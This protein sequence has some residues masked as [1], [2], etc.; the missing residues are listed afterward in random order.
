MNMLIIGEADSLW[1]KNV[2]DKTC[3][4]FNDKITIITPHN[5]VFYEYY[6]NN[7]VCVLKF[8]EKGDRFD[9][10]HKIRIFCHLIKRYDLINFQGVFNPDYAEIARL[11]SMFSKKFVIFFWGSDLLRTNIPNKKIY[12]ALK[13][14]S[15]IMIS[16][17]SMLDKFH[18]LYGYKFEKKIKRTNYGSNVIEL[19]HDS[20]FDDFSIRN[21]YGIKEDS[22]IIAI[23]YNRMTEQQHLNILDAFKGVLLNDERSIHFIL[24]MTYGNGDKSYIDEVRECLINLKCDFT[25]FQDYLTDE[26]IAEITYITDVFIQGQTTDAR[27]ASMCEHLYS[28]CLVI[29]PSWLCYPDICQV[30][31][32]LN[33]NSFDE[34][35]NILLNTLTKKE[36]SA[37]FSQ[38]TNNAESI[39]NICSWKTHVSEW[40]DIYSN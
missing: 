34:L 6:K 31:Y 39:Y 2:V 27:S 8:N 4:P 14:A 22:I 32:Y 35:K 29:N 38:L 20:K 40:R 11:C 24:R 9:I 17:D 36:N 19:L 33:Y 16:T 30:A 13:S 5:S 28:K 21:K 25:I 23:G 10:R 37:Y 3:L 18:D 7:N 15:S 1:I 12:H 26:E